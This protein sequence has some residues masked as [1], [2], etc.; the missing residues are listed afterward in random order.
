[1]GAVLAMMVGLSLLVGGAELVVRYGSRLA[2][3]IGVPPVVVGLTVVSLGTSAPELAVAIEAAR[4]GA[5]SLAI[6]N[7]AGANLANLL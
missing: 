4:T 1:M 7:L 2:R 5:V 6:G 3:Q